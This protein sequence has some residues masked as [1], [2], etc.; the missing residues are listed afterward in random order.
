M[1]DIFTKKKRSEIMSL[2]RSKNTVA[3]KIVFS[4]L[5][6]KKV[7]FRK[8]YA[9]A[10]GSPDIARPRE[11]KAVFIDGDFWHG[12]EYR[13]L[14]KG[15]SENDFWVKKIKGNMDRDKRQRKYL[16]INGWKLLMV[17]ESDIKRKGTRN[18]LLQKIQSFLTEK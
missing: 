13:S 8:H 10:I 7:Y 14:R 11:K 1:T 15:K 18:D 12:R 6:S 4:Y 2:V 5:R 16:K 17:W 9:G 3:E